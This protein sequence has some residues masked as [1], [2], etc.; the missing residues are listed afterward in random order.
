M[1]CYRDGFTFYL[2][3]SKRDTEIKLRTTHYERCHAEQRSNTRKTLGRE[4]QVE[5]L[6]CKTTHIEIGNSGRK[7]LVLRNRMTSVEQQV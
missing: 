3:T 4:R 1:A 6:G 2:Y 7:K 5:G